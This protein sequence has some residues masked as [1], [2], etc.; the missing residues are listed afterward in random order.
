LPYAIPTYNE[1]ELILLIKAGDKKAFAY[2]YENYS[3]ALYGVILNIVKDEHLAEDVLQESFVKIWQKINLYDDHKGR[4]YTWLHQITHNTAIDKLRC[5]T[6]VMQKKVT[7]NED[8][9]RTGTEKNTETL[10]I[11]ALA[12][13]LKPDLWA[14]I[15]LSYYQGFTLLQISQILNIPLGTVKTRARRAILQLRK[16]YEPAQAAVVL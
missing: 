11:C 7:G 9:I 6:Q 10:G 2:L 8:H 4:M 16:I 3:A 14:V 1:T 5:K 12:Q 13:K 15:N